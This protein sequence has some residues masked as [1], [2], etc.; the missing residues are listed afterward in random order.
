MAK[1]TYTPEIDTLRIRVAQ[2]EG[3]FA[4]VCTVVGIGAPEHEAEKREER[5]NQL[6][7]RLDTAMAAKQSGEAKWARHLFM[8][9]QGETQ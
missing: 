6:R 8:K 2:L 7:K 5:L 9:Q 1:K 3:L 4:R